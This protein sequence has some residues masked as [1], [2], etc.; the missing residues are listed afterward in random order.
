MNTG[1][2]LILTTLCLVV[3]FSCWALTVSTHPGKFDVFD[4][5]SHGM[6]LLNLV[7]SYWAA[8]G[9][10]AVWAANRR[11]VLLEVMAMSFSLGFF[12]VIAEFP[13][14]VLGLD[15]SQVLST[16]DA[17]R[18]VRL[19][20]SENPS[21]LADDELLF[22]HRPNS[23]FSGEV[24]GDLVKLYGIATDRKYH[25]DVAYDAN[26]FRNTSFSDQA[27]IVV[28]GDSFIE[29][30]LIPQEQTLPIRIASDL[31]VS[32]LNMGVSGY[33]PEQERITLE[34]YGLPTNPKY[35][36]WFFFEGNDLIDTGRFQFM[37]D[38]HE[39]KPDRKRKYRERSFV[40]NVLWAFAVRTQKPPT[41]DAEGARERHCRYERAIDEG[42]RDVYFAFDSAQDGEIEHLESVQEQ[43]LKA[44]TASEKAGAQFVLVYV[45]VKLRILREFCEFEQG[46]LVEGWRPDDFPSQM[47]D[48]AAREGIHY[49]DLIPALTT[50]AR[51]GR[52]PYFPDDGHWNPLAHEIAA[53][54]VV[55]RL[56]EIPQ[57]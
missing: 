3:A 24:H 12:V 20:A 8:W 13:A 30:G 22:R 38:R 1:K 28:I 46:T 32:V 26:G 42:L 21:N 56:R 33:G 5:W 23:S 14:L 17:T 55:K 40:S 57:L 31:G 45:P 7:V 48:F 10:R 54:V 29:A 41:T 37:K 34:R 15:Y 27:D 51:Q 18:F 52:S 43:I 2:R 6:F 11:R 44:R 50:S 25:V 4:R 9:L 53:E 47:A 36:L 19:H 16:G 35:V 39:A 49:I